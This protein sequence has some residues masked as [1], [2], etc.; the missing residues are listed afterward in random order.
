M[1]ADAFVLLL[2]FVLL[3]VATPGPANLLAMA[4]GAHWGFRACLPFIIGLTC[5]KL[6]LNIMMALG[7]GALLAAAPAAKSVLQ[8]LSGIYLLWLAWRIAGTRLERKKAE[9]AAAPGFFS[10]MAVHPLNPKAWAM[11]TAAYAQ[12]GNPDGSWLLQSAVI[13]LTFFA[14]QMVV[15]PLWCYGG[16]R[17]AALLGG[18]VWERVLMFALAGSLV[19][20]VAWAVAGY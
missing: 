9:D 20:L 13:I 7:L 11:L 14:V 18:T 10:G 3:M 6:A 12:F 5:G 19:A 17:L 4:A 15:H 16:M 2:S 8:A 1:P